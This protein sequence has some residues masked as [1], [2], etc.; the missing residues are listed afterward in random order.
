MHRKPSVFLGS[1]SESIDI[2]EVLQDNLKDIADVVPWTDSATFPAGE[3]TL[4]S[5][6]KARFRFDF[7]LLV[8]GRDDVVTSRGRQLEAP[9]DNVVFE[10]GLFMSQLGQRRTLALHPG[11]IGAYK[12][13]SDLSGLT[14]IPYDEQPKI[15]LRES[16]VRET[17]LKGALQSASEQIRKIIATLGVRKRRPSA[18]LVAMDVHQLRDKLYGLIDELERDGEPVTIDNL[19]HDLG[20]TWPLVQHKLFQTT[21][22]NIHWRTLMV[23]PEARAIQAAAGCGIALKVARSR[24]EDEIPSGCKEAEHDLRKRRIVFECRAYDEPTP[25]HGFLVDRRHLLIAM[26][27]MRPDGK[28]ETQSNPY[29][30]YEHMP[31]NP[32][33]AQVVSAFQGWFNHHWNKAREVGSVLP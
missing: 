30:T 18:S 19:G 31:D 24:I 6:L 15:R 28:M 27:I 12:V 11:N 26:S 17:Y 16:K 29:W 9:R 22:R 5:L 4:Q 20:L 32:V 23:N 33:S 13:L 2:V 25:F 7:A 10:L 3:F 1:S 14:L 21:V 8:F